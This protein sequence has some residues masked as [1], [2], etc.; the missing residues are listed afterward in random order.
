MKQ[1]NLFYKTKKEVSKETEVT[2][3]KLLLRGDFVE[4]LS[5]G[6]Y[7]FLP[8]G[9]RVHRKIENI[10]REEMKNIG[11]QELF[12]P[13]IQPKSLWE[14][15]DR[16]GNMAPPLFKLK[17]QHE[18]EYAL[19]P[20][21]EEVITTLAK[22]RI[23]SYRDLPQ[24]VFQI[25]N[26]FRNEVRATGGL[27]RTREFM[28]KDLY[29]FHSSEKDL[30]KYY[31]KVK[32]AYFKIFERCELNP[33]MV[34]ADPGSIGGSLSHE[35]MIESPS[36]EDKVLACEKCGFGANVEK[37]G[38]VDKCP[39][40]GGSL[41][42]R[43]CIEEAHAFYLGDK[44]SEALNATFTTKKGEEKPVLMGCYGIGIG[45][46][47]ATVAEVSHDDNGII[48][49]EEVSPFKVHLIK[50]EDN[51]KVK[52]KTSKLY[53]DLQKEK[54][55]VLYDDRDDIGAGEK[56]VE[57]DLFGIPYRVVV[58]EN[59]LSEDSVEIKGR[60]ESEA[61]LIDFD[62]AVNEIKETYVQ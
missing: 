8:L 21:H 42:Q 47:M 14:K 17:D 33:I 24:A 6:I 25:Q 4:Q 39:E 44:Y 30:K 9:W 29:S 26:K 16:W 28:M 13:S 18:R 41:K 59:T 7:S 60:A 31:E 62:K 20:T 15:S 35:F 46:L 56:F 51:K 53:R 49:P 12:L 19:G 34:E 2:S 43:N 58:S 23:E 5:S 3:H 55:E 57:S 40:C 38:E 1:T 22:T 45:R 27:L 54:I 61:E 48:W 50:I 11:A 36:G 32:E 37:V 10:I 52:N